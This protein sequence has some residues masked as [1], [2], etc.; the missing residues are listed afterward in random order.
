MIC[1]TLLCHALRRTFLSERMLWR[2][3]SWIEMGTIA[4][5]W[6]PAASAKPPPNEIVDILNVLCQAVLR[7]VSTVEC[8]I[9]KAHT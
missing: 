5:H 3:S 8:R 1:W 6:F 9:D 7:R 2:V 4:S